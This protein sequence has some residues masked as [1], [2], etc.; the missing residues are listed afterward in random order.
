VD[1]VGQPSLTALSDESGT[2]SLRLPRTGRRPNTV[3]RF[4]RASFGDRILSIGAPQAADSDRLERNVRLVPLGQSATVTGSVTGDDGSPVRRA[5]IQLFS[6]G[7]RRSFQAFS[8]DEGRFSL[9]DVEPANDYRLWIRAQG[10]YKDHVQEG[11]TVASEGASLDVVLESLGGAS[12][13]GFMLDPEGR[14]LPGFSLWIRAAYGPSAKSVTGDAAGRFAVGDLPEGPVTLETRALPLLTVT[15][16]QMTRGAVQEA[17]LTLDIG[18]HR[19]EGHLQTHEA[20][21]VAGARVTLH[22]S[23]VEGGLKSQSFRES[24]S[25]SSGYFLFTQLAAGLHTLNV[26]ATGFGNKSLRQ[27]VGFD[28]PP[29]EVQLQRSP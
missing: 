4:S 18:A 21:P 27:Q 25:D 17:R 14:P 23:F 12:L 29:I 24:V 5:S 8:D 28:T 2:Y 13:Q 22:W 10:Q 6:T 20:L 26:T 15:G 19:L 9:A 3:L 7:G 11:V 16:I 1:V